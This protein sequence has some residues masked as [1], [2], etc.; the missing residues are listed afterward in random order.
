MPVKRTKA[1]Q[2]ASHI[3]A[4][5]AAAFLAGDGLAL[6]NALG[7]RPWEFTISPTED[8][9]EREGWSV[10]KLMAHREQIEA[11]LHDWERD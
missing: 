11:E 5:A 7:L 3:T 9:A 4:E 8:A 6:R 10:E 2:R 1:K